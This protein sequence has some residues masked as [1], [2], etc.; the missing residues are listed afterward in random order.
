MLAF[1]H[2]ETNLVLCTTIIESGLD[3]PNANTMI[4]NR[5]DTFGL[6]QLYQLRG[7]VGRSRQRA[8]AYFLIPGEGSISSDA[9]ERLK[10]MQEL[11]ELGAGF[12]IATHDLEIR[13]AGDL[14][15]AKQSG[16]IAAVGFELYTELLE[17]AVSKLKGEVL[18]ER[19]EP[20]IN[21]KI[22]AFIPEDYIRNPNQRLVIYKKLAQS[23]SEDDIHSIQEELVDRFGKFPLAVVYLLEVMK[24]RIHLKTLLVK[25]F[26]FDGKRLICAFHEKT[27]VSPDLI[28]SLIRQSAKKYRFTPD[29]R[30]YAE[31]SDTT[32][33]GIFAEARNLLKRL[34]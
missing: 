14:L 4:V 9:R 19:V 7:R 18:T 13:G 3:I 23:S 30:L 17:E 32:F 26:E 5:A 6:A 20:E 10:I 25:K 16:N 8:F 22:P 12:R 1:L 31:L 24:L 33:E 15:G 21:L 2:G 28:I 27:P 11:T 29:F 34:S